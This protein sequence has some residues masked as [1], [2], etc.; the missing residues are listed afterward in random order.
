MH[1]TTTFWLSNS[2]PNLT[3]SPL[4]LKTLILATSS[5]VFTS[6]VW[7]SDDMV[8]KQKTKTIVDYLGVAAA[9][10]NLAWDRGGR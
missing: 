9:I 6:M 2:E 4:Q 3:P 10:G 8:C 7:S 5:S 1:T